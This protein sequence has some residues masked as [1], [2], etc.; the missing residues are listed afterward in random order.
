M[1]NWGNST[2]KSSVLLIWCETGGFCVCC[3]EKR[4]PSLSQTLELSSNSNRV[5]GGNEVFQ[6]K[7]FSPAVT[8]LGLSEI[9]R[10]EGPWTTEETRAV[11]TFTFRPNQFRQFSNTEHQIAACWWKTLH[12]SRPPKSTGVTFLSSTHTVNTL[13]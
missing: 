3:Y 7:L 11:W 2:K 10:A 5:A 1:R 8:H 6:R 9:H 12:Y 4:S 13:Q